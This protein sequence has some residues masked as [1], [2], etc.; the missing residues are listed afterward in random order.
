LMTTTKGCVF[1]DPQNSSMVMIPRNWYTIVWPINCEYNFSKCFTSDAKKSRTHNHCYNSTI[2]RMLNKKM[3]QITPKQ[4]QQI[5]LQ[6]FKSILEFKKKKKKIENWNVL[7]AIRFWLMIGT[8]TQCGK[9]LI[10]DINKFT[11][12]TN[13]TFRSDT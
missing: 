3:I 1:D 8:R 7:M 6:N 9:N 4:E 11:Y 10:N 2:T 12:V 13:D 5:K